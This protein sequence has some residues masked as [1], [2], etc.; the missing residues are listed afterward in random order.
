MKLPRNFIYHTLKGINGNSEL[1]LSIID[2][3]RVTNVSFHKRLFSFFDKNYPFT[4]TINY[5]TRS[6]HTTLSPVLT[7]GP[8]IGIGLTKQIQEFQII[9]KRYKTEKECED[10]INEINNKRNKLLKIV[11]HI[12]S[13]DNFIENLEKN[14]EKIMECCSNPCPKY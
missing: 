3:S 4:I 8:A 12:H 14:A 11:N 13:T 6:E 10:E 9:T 2:V 5:K 7:T 1:K